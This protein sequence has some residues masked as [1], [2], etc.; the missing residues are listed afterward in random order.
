MAAASYRLVTTAERCV[1]VLLRVRTAPVV[2]CGILPIT[3]IS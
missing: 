2:C 1:S 3:L